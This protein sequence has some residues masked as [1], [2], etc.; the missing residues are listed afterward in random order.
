MIAALGFFSRLVNLF[1][2]DLSELLNA[3]EVL[4]DRV[5]AARLLHGLGLLV[6]NADVKYLIPFKWQ[7][8]FVNLIDAGV[9]MLR[10]EQAHESA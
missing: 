8:C 3:L 2:V 4:A 7:N 5:Y 9:G 6:V 10:F 1:A